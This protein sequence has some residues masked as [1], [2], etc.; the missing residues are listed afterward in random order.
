MAGLLLSGLRFP[1]L[2]AMSALLFC[3]VYALEV[4]GGGEAARCPGG[5][6][7]R[8]FSGGLAQFLYSQS[9]LSGL[10]GVLALLI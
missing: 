5:S 10:Y 9:M 1:S 4:G 3:W 2:E 6:L 8:L 7:H